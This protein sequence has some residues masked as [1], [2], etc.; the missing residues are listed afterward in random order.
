MRPRVVLF[1]AVVA[2]IGI[3]LGFSL[4][5]PVGCPL[6]IIGLLIFITGIIMLPK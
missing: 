1:G 5:I 3:V 2:N 6:T 4:D